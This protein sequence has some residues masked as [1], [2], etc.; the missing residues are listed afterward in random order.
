MIKYSVSF[1]V[2]A[3]MDLSAGINK[4][5][6][7]LMNQ[8]VR[9]IAQATVSDW[10]HAIQRGKMWSGEKDAYEKSIK[11][12]MVGDFSAMVTS[13]Y[14]YCEDIENGRP[15]RDLKAMLDTSQ[16]VRRTKDGRRFLIIPIRHNTTGHNALARDMPSGVNK[17]AS[18]MTPSSVV[19][20]SQRPSGQVTL[21]SP[22]SGMTVSRNQTPYLSN[23]SNKLA[24]TVASRQYAWGDR[25]TRAALK[26]AGMGKK[27]QKRYAGMVRMNTVTP[28]GAKSSSFLTF[29]VMMEGSHGW[30]VPAQPGQYIARNVATQM[31]PKAEAAFALAAARTVKP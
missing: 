13:D 31:Q 21:L 25:I 23:R 27:D 17:L 26:D 29:R 2:G 30:M 15:P 9:A 11:W 4:T 24:Q 12:E 7:P 14:K 1:N 18:A 19:T 28:G 22:R 20:E 10:G 6:L 3:L 16:K 8:A 5:V